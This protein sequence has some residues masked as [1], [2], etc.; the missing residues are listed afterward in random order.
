MIGP[1][2]GDLTKSFWAVS[3]QVDRTLSPRERTRAYVDG[4][5]KLQARGFRPRTYFQ[6]R[7]KTA[8]GRANERGS[9]IAKNKATKF[10][11]FVQKETGVKMVVNEGCFL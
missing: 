6:F 4:R 9:T 10:A 2:G 5:A 7:D 11:E 1:F 8:D 3:I